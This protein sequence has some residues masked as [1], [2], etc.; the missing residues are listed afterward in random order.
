M[1]RAVQIETDGG[2]TYSLRFSTN[3]MA[4]YQE[5]AGETITAALREVDRDS[6]SEDLDTI[7]IRRL[8]W[9]G[10]SG[11]GHDMDEAA[12]GDV[13]DEIG[14]QTAA[15]RLGDAL[16]AAFPDAGA[17]AGNGRAPSKKKATARTR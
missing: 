12:A 9:A 17:S 14:I 1:R 2:E 10:L 13:M 15:V 8:F 4:L 11:G 3:A 7:R 16:R 6:Q 5:R